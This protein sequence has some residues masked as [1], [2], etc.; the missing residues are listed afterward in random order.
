V[1]LQV[2][3][4]GF[5][6]A[7][8]VADDPPSNRWPGYE[9]ARGGAVVGTRL[10]FSCKRRPNSETVISRTRPSCPLVFNVWKKP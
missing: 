10:P 1:E 4:V 2:V 8:V 3:V 9:Q 5:R 7:G 6:Q